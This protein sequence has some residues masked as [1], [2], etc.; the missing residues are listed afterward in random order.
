[1]YD[2][3]ATG[4]SKRRILLQ[5]AK[6]KNTVWKNDDEVDESR[7]S[8]LKF[9]CDVYLLNYTIKIILKT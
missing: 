9:E 5:W 4:L 8:Q 3:K 6:D 1:M 2:P 7:K